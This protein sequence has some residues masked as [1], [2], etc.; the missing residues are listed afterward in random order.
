[1]LSDREMAS[2]ALWDRGPVHGR[3]TFD[4]VGVFED[5]PPFPWHLVCWLLQCM[6]RLVWA[7]LPNKLD[8]AMPP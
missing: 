6:A 8:L 3:I 4:F 7:V 5:T 2:L 1:M